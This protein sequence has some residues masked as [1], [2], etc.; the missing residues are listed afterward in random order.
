MRPLGIA[1]ATL[2]KIHHRE[3]MAALLAYAS[4]SFVVFTVV[5][6][7]YGLDHV[8]MDPEKGQK[9]DWSTAAYYSIITMTSFTPPGE[10]PPR[11]KTARA[12]I[13]AQAALSYISIFWL[14]MT[15][16]GTKRY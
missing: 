10:M 7:F 12:I 15:P 14:I 8:N 2:T 5:W 9:K 1:L 16:G 13:A 3:P 4:L 11:D 6:R